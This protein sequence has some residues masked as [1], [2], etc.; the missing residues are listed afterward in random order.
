[1][2]NKKNFFRSKVI[3]ITGGTGSIGSEVLRSLILLKP[4]EIRV[5]SRDEYKQ[6]RLK[7]RY[8]NIK[9]VKYVLGDVRDLEKLI[10]ASRDVDILFHCA[11]LKHVP[12]SEEMPEEFIKTNI[13]GAVN[14]TKAALINQ[15]SCTVSISTDKVV[16]PSNVM[17]LTKAIQEKIFISHSINNKSSKQK[18]IN[19]RFGN[20]IG[21]H[22]SLFPILYHQII[23]NIPLTV[24]ESDM[25]RFFMS[26]EEAVNLIFW[27]TMNIDDGKTVI[28][29]MKSVKIIDIVRCFLK[30]LGKKADYPIKKIGIR[31]GEK[32]HEHLITEEE[33]FRFREKEGYF[34]VH[35][36]SATDLAKNILPFD[37]T[38]KRIDLEDFC[39]NNEE[40]FMA[41]KELK[42]YI[43]SYIKDA[44]GTNDYI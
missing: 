41:G 6:H 2:P 9:N 42:N 40:N 31:P 38:A 4:K 22:G 39:S 44:K 34:I 14:I 18:F 10:S 7:Y 37:Q 17:G 21:T 30:V 1:M 11:A 8:S 24:T 35:P 12:V 3:L 25:T 36:Y 29:K 5:Y 23:N 13:L 33:M 28:K 19:V 32:M 20:V 15:I 16:N 27:A 43:N 26:V